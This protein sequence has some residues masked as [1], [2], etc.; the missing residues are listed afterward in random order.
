M[1]DQSDSIHRPHTAGR[2]PTNPSTPARTPLPRPRR[3]SAKSRVGTSVRADD[4]SVARRDVE[5]ARGRGRR[6]RRLRRVRRVGRQRQERRRRGHAR[7]HRHS[8]RRA[9]R[10]GL[11]A[12]T[13]WDGEELACVSRGET[14]GPRTVRRQAPPPLRAQRRVI[15][16]SR[17]VHQHRE[18]HARAV[19]APPVKASGQREALGVV[20]RAGD[21]RRRALASGRGTPRELRGERCRGHERRQP[22][23][24]GGDRGE[25]KRGI[26]YGR[27]E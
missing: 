1:P 5:G 24:G 7:G 23:R 14:R 6:H 26:A 17:A 11:Q 10:G 18:R 15:H 9:H 22:R 21:G 4:R 2:I 20:R 8:H 3:S 19:P 27:T 25:T 16:Q 13:R 12:P